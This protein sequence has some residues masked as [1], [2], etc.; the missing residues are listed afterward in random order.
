MKK[1]IYLGDGCYA[2][3]DGWQIRL[4]APREEGDH[5]IYLE[6]Q[7]LHALNEYVKSLQAEA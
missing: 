2:F 3:Y 5:V 6:P 4:R 1:E 7:L